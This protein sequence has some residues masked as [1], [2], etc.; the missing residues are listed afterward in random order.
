MALDLW[1]EQMSITDFA[2]G[3]GMKN[4]WRTMLSRAR[5][6]YERNQSL[7][8]ADRVIANSEDSLGLSTI[9][10]G[11]EQLEGKVFV[12]LM[13]ALPEEIR[14]PLLEAR[15]NRAPTSMELVHQALEWRAPGRKEDTVV[16]CLSL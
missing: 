11:S 6:A 16:A 8:I 4:H 9:S 2:V 1:F 5:E 7:S 3:K 14:R 10:P 13:A 15:P 12:A